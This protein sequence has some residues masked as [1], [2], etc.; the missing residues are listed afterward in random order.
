ML[1]SNEKFGT[2]YGFVPGKRPALAGSMA[3][4]DM[5]LVSVL[6]STCTGNI[7]NSGSIGSVIARCAP[8]KR[9]ASSRLVKILGAPTA[10]TVGT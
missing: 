1:M 5:P 2:S 9:N 3:F 4:C 10:C 7:V 8:W 6:L